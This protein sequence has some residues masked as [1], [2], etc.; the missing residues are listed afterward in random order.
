[1]A[2]KFGVIFI[3]DYT[4]ND[5]KAKQLR[6]ILERNKEYN[7]IWFNESSAIIHNTPKVFER[8]SLIDIGYG[9]SEIT[10]FVVFTN[11][12]DATFNLKNYLLVLAKNLNSRDIWYCENAIRNKNGTYDIELVSNTN[13]FGIGIVKDTF[14]NDDLP[15]LLTNLKNK[16][17]EFYFH[18]YINYGLPF[19][20]IFI[21]SNSNNPIDIDEK[22]KKLKSCFCDDQDNHFLYYPITIKDYLI[23][24]NLKSCFVF[25]DKSNVVLFDSDENDKPF[26]LKKY[27]LGLKE[28]LGFEPTGIF[29]CENANTHKIELISNDS[30]FKGVL[31]EFS[32]NIPKAPNEIPQFLTNFKNSKIPNKKILFSATEKKYSSTS[33]NKLCEYFQKRVRDTFDRY[34][35]HGY[36]KIPQEKRIAKIKEQ[37]KEEIKI[38]PSFCSYRVS[39]EQNRKINEIAESLK[40]GKIIGEKII[41]NAFNLNAS[42]CFITPDDLKNLKERLFIDIINAINQKKRVVLDH[43][44]IDDIQ[45]NLLDSAFYFIFDVGNPSQLAIKVPRKYL[46]NDELPN[47]KKNIFHVLIRSIHTCI[48]DESSF[49]END[50]TINDLNIQDLLGQLKTQAFPLSDTIT[51]AINQKEKGVALDYALIN[52][53]KYNLLDNT[54]HFI[55][56]VGNPLLKESS[57]L[58]IEVPREALDLENVDRLVEYTLSPY[59]NYSQSSLVYHI[60]EGS[61][62]IDLHLID[63]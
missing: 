40:S 61:Y 21:V 2:I 57:Q 17:I 39:S 58:I 63:D 20:I 38:N 19:G 18:K 25:Q 47:T 27:L 7:F 32:E 15:Q 10:A 11:E 56:D 60:S 41:A 9:F 16:Q 33:L 1:M 45:Y 5:R 12:S 29:Y 31:L 23:L 36:S 55:F 44:Q 42:Y 37:V 26:N 4:I 14:N 46:E 30:D 34:F 59:N 28:K 54:F 62:I 8:E 35:W 50:K 3:S 43:A 51:N 49:L 53:I 6:S 48:D 22:T 24:D 52:D 13:D